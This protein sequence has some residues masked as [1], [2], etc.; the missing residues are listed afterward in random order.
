MNFPGDFTDTIKNRTE[1][2]RTEQNRTVIWGGA[3]KGV[4]FALLKTRAGQLINNIIDINPAKQGKFIAGT[5][6]AIKSPAQGLLELKEGDTIFV[7]NSNYLDEIK[8]MT[9]NKYQYITVDSA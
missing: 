5:G 7:M 3:S 4:I 9:D 1:Q 8:D 6:L 2:N